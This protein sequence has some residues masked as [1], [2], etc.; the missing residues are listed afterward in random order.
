MKT[1]KLKQKP[2]KK[3]IKFMLHQAQPPPPPPSTFCILDS[4]QELEQ[5]TATATATSRS[6]NFA[7]SDMNALAS[8]TSAVVVD[9]NL[10]IDEFI[11]KLPASDNIQI[12]VDDEHLLMQLSKV[13]RCCLS[14]L[15]AMDLR[16]IFD[17]DNCIA[18]MI[19]S[20]AT[21]Q[22][23]QFVHLFRLITKLTIYT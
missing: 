9:N 11:D 5:S 12:I 17:N 14:E 1:N 13:C 10:Q 3:I 8:A 21:V 22:V 23:T 7:V 2:N 20:L 16:E 4:V 15:D 18:E 19:M 6:S